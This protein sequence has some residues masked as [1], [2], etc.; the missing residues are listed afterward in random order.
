[1]GSECKHD[2]KCCTATWPPR[3]GSNGDPDPLVASYSFWFSLQRMEFMTRAE[4]LCNCHAMLHPHPHRV[5]NLQKLKKENMRHWAVGKQTRCHVLLARHV[6][7]PDTCGSPAWN[8]L[9]MDSALSH[10][11]ASFRRV[12]RAV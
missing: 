12:C 10:C 4:G 7:S 6:L 2:M 5:F 3:S 11:A 9:L 1:L 8:V